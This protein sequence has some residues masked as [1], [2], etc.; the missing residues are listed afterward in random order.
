MSRKIIL[1]SVTVVQM[2][3]L[4]SEYQ[5]KDGFE[6]W[7]WLAFNEI[8]HLCEIM[9]LAPKKHQKKENIKVIKQSIKS[10]GLLESVSSLQDLISNLPKM[11]QLNIYDISTLNHLSIEKAE[12]LAPLKN[13]VTTALKIVLKNIESGIYLQHRPREELKKEIVEKIVEKILNS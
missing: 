9:L 7:L 2:E 10:I 8:H 12:S 5:F 11:I 3:L 13:S 6:E 4:A 1:K